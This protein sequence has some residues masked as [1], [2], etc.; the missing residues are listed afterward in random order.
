MAKD[1][2][3][4]TL[5][6]DV[7]AWLSSPEVMML[8]LAGKGFWIQCL[9]IMAKSGKTGRIVAAIPNLA[10]LINCTEQEVHSCLNEIKTAGTADV[11]DCDGVVTVTN[12]R[13]LRE[14]TEREMANARVS[15]SRGKQADILGLE[16][17]DSGVATE[18][19]RY[20]D[21]FWDAYPYKVGKEA[22]RKSFERLFL[23][24]KLPKEQVVLR[25]IS[26]QKSGRQWV[27]D[28]GAFIPH[29]STWLN[30]HRWEDQSDNSVLGSVARP[31]IG[32]GNL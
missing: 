18:L 24:G 3:E 5:E 23:S 11:N 25:A 31:S 13:M 21:T 12:R 27:K 32:R 7:E 28:G 16:P 19:Q 29:P 14:F 20:F 15:K 30:Q 8:S 4:T 1:N 22:A 26:Q 17:G 9:N 6:W 2:K 10:R